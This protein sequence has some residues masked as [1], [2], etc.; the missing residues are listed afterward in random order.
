MKY[1]INEFA[2]EIRNLFPGNYD[3]LSDSDLVRLWLR[4]YP[5]DIEKVEVTTRNAETN[6]HHSFLGNVTP[7]SPN[8]STFSHSAR[9]GQRISREDSR[10]FTPHYARTVGQ[11]RHQ[12]S[13]LGLFIGIILLFISVPTLIYVIYDF[14]PT[15]AE[16][17]LNSVNDFSQNL[18]GNDLINCHRDKTTPIIFIVVSSILSIIGLFQILKPKNHS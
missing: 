10:E 11:H 15:D 1:T 3:D 16:K 7:N 6:V 18:I 4:K 8:D 17:S 2:R 9:G 14:L 5:Q 12:N 13:N